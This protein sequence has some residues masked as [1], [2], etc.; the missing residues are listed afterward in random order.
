MKKKKKKSKIKIRKIKI[1]KATIFVVIFASVGA[2]VL[3]VSHAL[4]PPLHGLGALP[5][6]ST[7]HSHI[8]L[9]PPQQS[10]P[11]SVNISQWAP[12]VGDQGQVN[13]CVA[14]AVGHSLFG[15]YANYNGYTDAGTKGTG[16]QAPMYIYAQIAKGQD[17]GSYVSQNFS[18]AQSQGI[19]TEV[20]YSQGDYNYT[21]QPTSAE[22]S[23]AAQYKISSYFNI[24]TGTQTSNTAQVLLEAQLASGF[25]AVI[26]LPIYPEFDNANSSN[27]LV[28][29]PTSGQVSRGYHEI[30]AF[31]Y[32]SQGLLVENQW[33][34][35]WGNNGWA[36]LSWAFVNKYLVAA[37]AIQGIS[38]T[39]TP[40]L[41]SSSSLTPGQALLTNQTLVSPNGIYELNMQ[42]D[43]NLVLYYYTGHGGWRAYWGT[44]TGGKGPSFVDMQGDG[45]L[46]VYKNTGGY[47]WDSGTYAGYGPATLD[48]QTDGNLVIYQ[49]STNKAIWDYESG[50]LH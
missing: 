46:V 14:W 44:G 43:G 15:W 29:T 5:P 47:T 21:T 48:M 6:P 30:T 7:V 1:I 23:N 40:P 38:G 42:S 27:S 17:N 16:M 18:I 22:R 28:G 41:G 25:P 10:F 11:A 19:D 45:N 4:S 36:T 8:I 31:G 12:Y 50:I 35:G 13:S 39:L 9:P 49:V 32:T 3:L 2:I 34:T 37:D 24:F 20:D 26:T 33:G